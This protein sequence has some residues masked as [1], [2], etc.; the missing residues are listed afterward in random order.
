MINSDEIMTKSIDE[1]LDEYLCK[2]LW[3][4]SKCGAIVPVYY[5]DDP[6][7]F[8]WIRKASGT[9]KDPSKE[10]A[11]SKLRRGPCPRGGNHDWQSLT[12]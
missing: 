7:L 3:Q 5:Y 11:K 10:A 4:C 6:L 1:K 9:Y 8:K 2:D 12:N